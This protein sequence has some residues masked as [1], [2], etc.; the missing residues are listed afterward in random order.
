[1]SLDEDM[2]CMNDNCS[3][4][5]ATEHVIHV[6][7]SHSIHMPGLSHNVISIFISSVYLLVIYP[8]KVT[9]ISLSHL[10]LNVKWYV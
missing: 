1:M 6:I 7:S 9:I 8:F 10:G 5:M 2:L 4:E 3:I